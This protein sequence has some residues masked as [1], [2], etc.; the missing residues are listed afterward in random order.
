MRRG[1]V[2]I[3]LLMVLVAL[4]LVALLNVDVFDVVRGKNRVQNGGDAAALAAAR[5]QGRLLNEIGKLN[6]AHLVAAAQDDAAACEELAMVQRR[7]ALLGPVEALRLANHA[8]KKN[9][10]EVRDEFAA[11]LREHV[12]DIRL[13]YSGGTNEEGEPYPE[14]YPGAWTEYATA[15]EDVISEGLACGVDNVPLAFDLLFF[16][17][18]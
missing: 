15:I 5:K 6:I 3:Y 13:V 10:M 9:G 17:H 12:K 4:F 8:A 2:A 1:Q 14:P 11:I 7:L 18:E 16:C